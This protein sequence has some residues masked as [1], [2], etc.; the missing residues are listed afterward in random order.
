MTH[1]T[2]QAEI[3]VSRARGR[4]RPYSRHASDASCVTVEAGGAM[5]TTATC[6]WCGRPFAPRNTRGN[7]AG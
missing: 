6:Q 2:V 4:E 1:V 7:M 5:T 3:P